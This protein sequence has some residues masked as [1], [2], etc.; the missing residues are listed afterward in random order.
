MLAVTSLTLLLT[1]IDK[2]ML[3]RLLDLETFGYYAF[4]GAVAGALFKFVV[5]IATA[6]YPKFVELRARGLDAEL[7]AAYHKSSQLITV[8]LGSAAIVLIVF[9]DDLLLIWTRDAE[10]ASTAAPL[11]RVLAAGTLLN[12]LMWTP[13]HIQLAFGWTSLTVKVNTVAVAILIPALLWMVPRYGALG[14][15]YAWLALNAGYVA[16]SVHF[17]HRRVLQHEKWRWY[18]RDLLIPL[19][20][21]AVAVALFGSLLPDE[22]GAFA[23]LAVVC[24][25]AASAITVS[26]LAAPTV[27]DELLRYLRRASGAVSAKRTE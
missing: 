1:Q 22:A 13:Y 23:V 26:G 8:V 10:L 14:A 9:A 3:S 4:A 25:C 19:A 21:A 17:M 20:A 27:R 2:V 15:A 16:F 6:F 12:G 7:S 11:L 5:P 18:I 24:L